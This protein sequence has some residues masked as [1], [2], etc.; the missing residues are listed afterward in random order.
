MPEAS[1]AAPAAP[2]PQK[3]AVDQIITVGN[4]KYKVKRLD[5]N[6]PDD[7]DVEEVQ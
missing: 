6:N 7:P 1:G 5:P 3:Y 4:K 2:K